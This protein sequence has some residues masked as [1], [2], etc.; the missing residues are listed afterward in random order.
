MLS[1]TC[2][3]DAVREIGLTKAQKNAIILRKP[4]ISTKIKKTKC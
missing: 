4:K 2:L 3:S 1:E